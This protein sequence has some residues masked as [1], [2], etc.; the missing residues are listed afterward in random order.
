ML[1]YHC[2]DNTTQRLEDIRILAKE[3]VIVINPY[4]GPSVNYA[5]VRSLPI[6]MLQFSPKLFEKLALLLYF[7]I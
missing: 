6:P 2:L 7:G 5:Y 4:V 1:V 3:Y